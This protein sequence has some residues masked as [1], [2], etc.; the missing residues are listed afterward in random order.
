MIYLGAA[1]V[2]LCW[3]Y[4]VWTEWDECDGRS[5]GDG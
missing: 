1:I 5:D 2:V 4:L 3:K